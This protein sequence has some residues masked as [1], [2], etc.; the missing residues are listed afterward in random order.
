VGKDLMEIKYMIGTGGVLVH[1]KNPGE[2]LS[3]GNFSKENPVSL[4]P[5]HPKYL[6]DKTYILS[7]MGL[8]AQDH[9][10]KAV[11]IM[12]KY[13]VEVCNHQEVI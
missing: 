8:L 2:I 10:D 7:A 12:K 3:A 11:R 1:S 13:L 4:R 5:Q 9:P 6:L